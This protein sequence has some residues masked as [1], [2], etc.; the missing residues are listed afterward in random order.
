MMFSKYFVKKPLFLVV[1]EEWDNCNIEIPMKYLQLMLTKN[2]GMKYVEKKQ[3]NTFKS[4]QH[5]MQ[6]S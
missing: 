4:L 1:T 5:Q 6:I 2:P 3:N